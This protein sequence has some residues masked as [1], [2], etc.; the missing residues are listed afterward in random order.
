MGEQPLLQNKLSPPSRCVALMFCILITLSSSFLVLLLVA[1]VLL[2]KWEEREK[3]N[4][5]SERCT[6]R[7]SQVR[8]EE[9]KSGREWDGKERKRRGTRK[10]RR[11]GRMD[12]GNFTNSPP[13]SALFGNHYNSCRYITYVTL[14]NCMT[15]S[16]GISL[17]FFVVLLFCCYPAK[18]RLLSYLNVCMM[19]S[20]NV[21][22]LIAPV[23]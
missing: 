12:R 5:A 13:S 17:F 6:G 15:F 18:Y 23:Q 2:W 8:E 1:I 16:I 10:R 20:S 19:P 14:H 11:E 22:F 9:K 7:K 3:E 21:S 4:E